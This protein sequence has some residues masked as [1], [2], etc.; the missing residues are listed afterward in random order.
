MGGHQATSSAQ[1]S[2]KASNENEDKGDQ[3][4][5][6]WNERKKDQSQNRKASREPATNVQAVAAA[7]EPGKLKRE[8]LEEWE[9]LAKSL[10]G[11]SNEEIDRATAQF[12]VAILDKLR[13]TRGKD[14]GFM[15][16]VEAM[17]DK[18]AAE[19]KQHGAGSE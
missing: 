8:S 4:R 18:K 2:N 3:K 17:W 1:A 9:K 19:L 16:R 11:K 12:K 6:R 5:G 7:A 15:E 14:K 13:P 10:Q